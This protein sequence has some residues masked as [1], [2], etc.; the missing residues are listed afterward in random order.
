MMFKS[1]SQQARASLGKFKE[2]VYKD[3]KSP[4]EEVR[5]RVSYYQS[6]G[7]LSQHECK[8]YMTLLDSAPS[9]KENTA[10]TVDPVIKHVTRELNEL[11]AKMLGISLPTRVPDNLKKPS[12][13]S[14][15]QQ[16]PVAENSIKSAAPLPVLANRSN[17]LRNKSIID[18]KSLRNKFSQDQIANLFV[19]TC[20]FARLGFVQPPCCLHCTY[21]E[22]LKEVTPNPECQRWVIW[23]RDAKTILHPNYVSDNAVAVQCHAARKLLAGKLVDYHKWDGSSKVLLAPKK[24]SRY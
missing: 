9:N 16:Q 15:Q 11:E 20:F 3:E 7:W 2:Y 5:E 8:K 14:S 6:K 24:T 23:R 19:E 17:N 4:L 22:S 10:F 13:T 1:A 21:K 18:P 12:S